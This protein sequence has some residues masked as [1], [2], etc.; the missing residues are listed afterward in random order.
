MPDA[1][2]D[3]S[4]QAYNGYRSGK[5]DKAFTPHPAIK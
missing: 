2:L 1:T 5:P 3:A 4:Y